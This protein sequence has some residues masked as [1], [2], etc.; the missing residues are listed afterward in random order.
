MP[1]MYNHRGYN[2][3]R[4]GIIFYYFFFLN[5]S[6]PL[7]WLLWTKSSN[8]F[9]VFNPDLKLFLLF[10]DLKMIPSVTEISGQS[11]L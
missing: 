3:V 11:E 7:W 2:A 6:L 10:A 4:N 1:W 5:L 9:I 8:L